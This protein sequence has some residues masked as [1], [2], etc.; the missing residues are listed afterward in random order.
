VKVFDYPVSNFNGTNFVMGGYP[1][2][3]VEAYPAGARLSG[4]FKGTQ[5]TPYVHQTWTFRPDGS[6]TLGETGERMR[7]VQGRYNL[8]GNTLD[9]G[10][11]RHTIFPQAAAKAGR[12][13]IDGHDMDPA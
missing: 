3:K 6:F 10:G 2:V 13:V 1:T 8:H 12:L 7:T 4:T 11:E 9:L 5:F